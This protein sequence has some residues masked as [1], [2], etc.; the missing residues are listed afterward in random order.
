MNIHAES[1]LSDS[2]AGMMLTMES[3]NDCPSQ[4]AGGAGA[5]K[6]LQGNAGCLDSRTK[7]TSDVWILI[8]RTKHELIS[9]LIAQMETNLRD[10]SIK[11]N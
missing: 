4:I 6:A 10:E 8:R 11:P 5:D 2:V 3:N 1:M 9:K 7:V